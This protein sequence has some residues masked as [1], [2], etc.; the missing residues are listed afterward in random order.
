MPSITYTYDDLGRLTAV[1]DPSGNTGIYT[2]D[3]VGNLIAIERQ[4]S[5]VVSIIEFAPKSAPVGTSITIHGTGFSY[6]QL[7]EKR[8]HI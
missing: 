5:S 8:G 4:S 6:R 7:S 1:A 3:A 2:Y